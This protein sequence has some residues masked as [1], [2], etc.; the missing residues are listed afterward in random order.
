[1]NRE[2]KRITSTTIKLFDQ[3]WLRSSQFEWCVCVLVCWFC[4]TYK[5][6]VHCEWLIQ[7]LL[8]GVCVFVIYR[9]ILTDAT[10]FGNWTKATFLCYT[11]DA[12][13]PILFITGFIDTF[14]KSMNCEKK[15]RM[16]MINIPFIKSAAN[17]LYTDNIKCGF[18]FS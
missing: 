14:A 17:Q 6:N 5:H 10:T 13:E 2:K 12:M 15:N 18:S 11:S 16:Q 1:M 8:S 3:I 7:G 4:F 9:Y